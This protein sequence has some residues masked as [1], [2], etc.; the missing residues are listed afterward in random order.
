M[1]DQSAQDKITSISV[2]DSDRQWFSAGFT[3]HFNDNANVDFGATYLLGQDVSVSETTVSSGVEV[4]NITATTH[5]DAILLAVQY[6]HS[7]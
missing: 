7:F 2:P 6:S 1:Y 4:S 3:Y 5:A